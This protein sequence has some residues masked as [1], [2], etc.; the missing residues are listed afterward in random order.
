MDVASGAVHA[1][2]GGNMVNYWL[3]NPIY[4]LH[5]AGGHIELSALSLAIAIVIALPIGAWVGHLH[6]FSF[7]AVNGSNVVRALP[8]LSVIAIGLS[9][10]GLGL[11]NITVGLVILGLP[12]ILTNSYVAVDQVDPNTVQAARG[13]GMNGWQILVDV[14]LP[15][16][17]PLIMAGVRVSWVYIV[18]TAYLAGIDAFNGTLG[19]VIAT[20]GST[21]LGG[22]LAAAAVSMAIAFLGDFILAGLQRALTP[23]GLRITPV[24]AAA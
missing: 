13:M 15:N 11:V 17:I 12:L 6:R 16:S 19:D 21:P 23:R 1:S 18:A 2:L 10:Y 24:A 8:T 7:I 20:T 9:I 3:N 5:L 4:L 14:E 22:V